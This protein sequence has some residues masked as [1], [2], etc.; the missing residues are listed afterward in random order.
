MGCRGS[1]SAFAAVPS[2]AG[3]RDQPGSYRRSRIPAGGVRKCSSPES[4][5]MG[6]GCSSNRVKQIKF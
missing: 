3:A 5:T 2:K 1:S 4:N 6:T